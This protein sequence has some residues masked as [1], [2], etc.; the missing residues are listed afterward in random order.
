M[1][2]NL[3]GVNPQLASAVQQII[4][5]SGGRV[6]VNSG[7]RDYALQSQLYS[8]AV[9]KYGSADAGNHVAP[10]GHSNHEKGLAVDLGG[11]LAFAHQLAS[12]L[13]LSF[14]MSWEPWHIEL[15]STRQGSSP[16]AY[17]PSPFGD[18]NPTVDQSIH[19]SRDNAIA[20]TV[21]ALHGAV[22]P[23]TSRNPFG[24]AM[25]EPFGASATGQAQLGPSGG[26]VSSSQQS[27][28]GG[29]VGGYQ[30]GSYGGQPGSDKRIP[31]H[32]IE[33]WARD[34]LTGLGAPITPANMS[35]MLRWANTESG[36]YNPGASG[37][38]FNPLNTTEGALGY[39]G[40]GG[41]QG[42]IKDF[43]SYEQGVN[44]QVYNLL[45]TRGA[46]YT[47]IVNALRQ[48]N[49]EQGVFSAINASAFGTHF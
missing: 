16:S 18:Q 40:Q 41:S 34:V 9:Q 45:H 49:N 26:G 35:A 5:L 20:M 47:G 4:N 14:P 28:P 42:N 7:Y 23:F 43:A 44:A 25:T 38:R 22:G 36:G 6:W 15:A 46:G 19:Q 21:D 33:G 3:D 27:A 37:G 29:A 31:G 13:G 32:S 17:T 24:G 2:A 11:D 8:Q 30:P 39:A 12:R 48:G 1:A 10:P